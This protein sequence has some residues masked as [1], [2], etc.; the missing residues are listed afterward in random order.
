MTNQPS[1]KLKMTT[2]ERQRMLELKKEL[3]KEQYKQQ[4]E[5]PMLQIVQLALDLDDQEAYYK[6]KEVFGG[7]ENYD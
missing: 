3:E 6:F 5:I 1:K 2:L 7:E 4:K